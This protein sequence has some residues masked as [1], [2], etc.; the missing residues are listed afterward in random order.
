MSST[1]RSIRLF[2]DKKSPEHTTS[3]DKDDLKDKIIQRF[4]EIYQYTGLIETLRSMIDDENESESESLFLNNQS[5][6]QV[7][8]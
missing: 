1:E 8:S 4:N 7:T 2:V 5:L 3:K 6:L